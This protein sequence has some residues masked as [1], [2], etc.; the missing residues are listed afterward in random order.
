MHKND[1]EVFQWLNQMSSEERALLDKVEGFGEVFSDM[2]F[3]PH[4]ITGDA[5][6]VTVNDGDVVY[7]DSRLLDFN[8]FSYTDFD[9]KVDTLTDCAGY[10]RP[11]E[12]LLCIDAGYADDAQVILHEMIHLHENWLH[13]QWGSYL[14]MDT[15]LFKLYIHLRERIPSLDAI[16]DWYTHLY[17]QESWAIEGGVHSVLFVLKSLDIDIRMGW[18]F[19]TT[20]SYES[21]D[22]IKQIQQENA[23]K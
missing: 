3:R 4:T 23:T 9:Y 5:L 10:Y 18:E 11:D 1:Y 13:E 20:A 12:H 7:D 16:V 2:L 22:T 19:G 15:L 21:V 14:Y 17:R 6:L 8:S